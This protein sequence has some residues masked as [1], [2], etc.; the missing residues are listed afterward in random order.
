MTRRRMPGAGAMAAAVALALAGGWIAF[1]GLS[2]LASPNALKQRLA[3]LELATI[4]TEQAPRAGGDPST[5]MAHALCRERPEAA[6]QALQARLASAAAAA[7]MATPKIVLTPPD[8]TWTGGRPAPILFQ[9]ETSGRYDAALS[10]L[11]ALAGSEPEI[12][13][14][15]MDVTSQTS[16]VSIKLSGRVLCSTSAA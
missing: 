10:M 3:A 11:K 8:V 13:A 4:R 7:D 12:F 6:G 16:T 9:L 15:Q 2:A 1:A 5:Y 14:D